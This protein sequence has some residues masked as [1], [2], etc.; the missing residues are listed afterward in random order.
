M[1]EFLNWAADHPWLFVFMLMSA[2]GVT[3]GLGG[4]FR[5]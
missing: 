5:R 3:H 1:M 4:W 2:S